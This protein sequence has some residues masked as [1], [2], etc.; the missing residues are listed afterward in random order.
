MGVDDYAKA[1]Q[2]LEVSVD[3]GY[4]HVRGTFAN[5]LGEFFRAQVT[6]GLEEDLEQDPP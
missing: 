6:L 4:V 5:R 1:L 3:G 2:L